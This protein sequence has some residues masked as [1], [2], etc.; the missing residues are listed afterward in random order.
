MADS[1]SSSLGA[2]QRPFDELLAVER[3]YLAD[4]IYGKIMRCRV[5]ATGA[6]VAIKVYERARAASH[7]T[8]SGHTV[9]VR[10]RPAAPRAVGTNTLARAHTPCLVWGRAVH[11][12][13][14]PRS[15]VS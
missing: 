10:P 3:S 2:A 1:N 11:R 14:L 6:L 13:T 5:K 9:L 8:R 4:T 15:W 7:R 12:K